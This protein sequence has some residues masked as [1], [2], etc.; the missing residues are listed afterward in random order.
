[1]AAKLPPDKTITRE[2]QF[3][4]LPAPV[5]VTLSAEGVTIAAKGCRQHITIDWQTLVDKCR[6]TSEV[7]AKFYNQGLELLQHQMKPTV[8]RL[9]RFNASIDHMGERGG[10][11]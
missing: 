5:N 3:R 1:M 6:T 9:A 8:T 7:P 4:F 2:M 11:K 10:L